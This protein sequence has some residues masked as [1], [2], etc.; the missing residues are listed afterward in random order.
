MLGVYILIIS[1]L[2]CIIVGSLVITRGLHDRRTVVYGLLTLSLLALCVANFLAISLEDNQIFFV[3]C[4]M[5]STTVAMYL[6]YVLIMELKERSSKNKP[7]YKTTLFYATAAMFIIDFTDLLFTGVIPGEPPKPIP[8]IGILFFFGLY[9]AT[10]GIGVRQLRKDTTMASSIN[11]KRRY[12]LL[13]AGIVPIV[14]LAPLTSFVM[15]NYLGINQFVVVTPLYAFI[16]VALVGYAIVRHGLFD[17]RRAVVRTMAYILSLFSL[18]V[19]YYVIAYAVS[20]TLFQGR[21]TTDFSVSPVNILLALVLAFLFQPIKRFFDKATDNFFY[22]DRYDSDD[23]FANL[24]QILSSTVDLRGLLERASGHI[25]KTLKAEQ[26][27]FYLRYTNGT[28]HFVSAGT[29]K[30]TRIPVYDIG[31]LDEYLEDASDTII[32]TD[33]LTEGS[34]AQK[35]L[36]SHKIAVTMP[37]RYDKTV[38]GYLLLGE[39]QAGSYAKRDITAL[40][41]ISNGLVI[42]IQNAISLHEVKEL[43]ATLQQRIDVATKELRASNAQLK[44]LDEVKDEFMSMASHQL[45]TP[46]TSVKGYISMVIEGDAGKITPQQHK[47]LAEAFKSSERMVGLIADFLNVSRLQTGKFIIDKKPFDLK[48][49]V[50]QEVADL[51]LMATTHDIKLRAKLGVGTFPVNA[52]EQK[53]RQVIMNFIDNAVYYSPA[54]STVVVSIEKV[55]DTA[56]VTIVDTGIGVPQAEQTRLFQKFFRAGNARKQR[57]DGTGVGLYLARR[58]VA[59]HGGQII[60]SSK[61]GKGSTFGFSLPLSKEVP[62]VVEKSRAVATR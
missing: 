55:K 38:M 44:H 51:Q 3:R 46:L 61:E 49:V 39:Q 16:F 28:H 4:V 36:R 13:I 23:F 54:N 60:F 59:A 26:A 45:R 22:H 41:T 37:L 19:I 30:H 42:A 47:L 24:N 48:N 27:M 1:V 9:I 57:P 12:A 33:L 50:R 52:D 32:V 2:A 43:N 56:A 17:V 21:S 8:N 14:F 11:E 15:P 10:L 35:M 53:L 62:A 18:A 40:E 29:E 7:Y 25:A 6:I 5:G 20:L 31:I 58:V 34:V